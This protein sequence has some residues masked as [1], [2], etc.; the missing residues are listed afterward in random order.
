MNDATDEKFAGIGSLLRHTDTT[1]FQHNSNL[2]VGLEGL[3]QEHSL[4]DGEVGDINTAPFSERTSG[5][6]VEVDTVVT[7]L[8]DLI[9]RDAR[10]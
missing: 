5:R 6:V 3:M 7:G 4:V 1:L 2:L 9:G 10:F 8:D